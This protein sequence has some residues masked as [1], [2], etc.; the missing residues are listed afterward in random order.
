MITSWREQGGG[1]GVY[2]FSLGLRKQST[3]ILAGSGEKLS[4]CSTGRV[5]CK[6]GVKVDVQLRSWKERTLWKL[7]LEEEQRQ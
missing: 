1:P 3:V 5:R 7:R 2:Y 6:Q 4:S